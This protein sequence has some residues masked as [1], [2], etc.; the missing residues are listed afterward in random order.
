MGNQKSQIDLI[1]TIDLKLITCE[2]PNQLIFPIMDH[3]YNMKI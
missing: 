1:Q 2:I 3:M